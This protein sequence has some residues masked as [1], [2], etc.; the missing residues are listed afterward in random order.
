MAFWFNNS[1]IKIDKLF[2]KEGRGYFD[3]KV[4]LPIIAVKLMIGCKAFG[5][6]FS[7]GLFT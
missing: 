4:S 5:N 6:V 2:Y 1:S 3:V 7:N